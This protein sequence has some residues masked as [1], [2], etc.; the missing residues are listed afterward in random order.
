[1]RTKRRSSTHSLTC[2][3]SLRRDTIEDTEAVQVSAL[4][5][6]SAISALVRVSMR[7]MGSEVWRSGLTPTG[8]GEMLGEGKEIEDVEGSGGFERWLGMLF[9]ILME[10]SWAIGGRC[11]GSERGMVRMGLEWVCYG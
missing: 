3:F 2:P 7:C 4:M 6:D 8:A 9:P 11:C 1:M 10:A 5:P